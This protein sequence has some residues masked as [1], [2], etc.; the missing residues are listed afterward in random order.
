MNVKC[1]ILN[2]KCKSGALLI[3]AVSYDRV[4]MS[5]N[6]RRILNIEV[7]PSRVEVRAG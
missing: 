5:N 3:I 7:V 2:N 1:R 6:E 4:L